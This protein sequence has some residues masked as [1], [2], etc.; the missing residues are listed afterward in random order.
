LKGLGT[1]S[2]TRTELQTCRFA[3]T[4]GEAVKQAIKKFEDDDRLIDDSNS[5]EI[6]VEV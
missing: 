6:E 2:V 5:I 4:R 3:E 1:L